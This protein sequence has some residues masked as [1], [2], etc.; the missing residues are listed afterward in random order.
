GGKQCVLQPT[1]LVE[2]SQQGKGVSREDGGHLK[3]HPTRGDLK[4]RRSVGS[5]QKG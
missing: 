3:D 1:S 5:S 2:G 4:A